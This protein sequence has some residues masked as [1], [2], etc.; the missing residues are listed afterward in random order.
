MSNNSRIFNVTRGFSLSFKQAVRAIEKECSADW[1]V[2]GMSIRDRSLAESLMAR[3]E[4]VR[5]REPLPYAEI[6]GLSY[7]PAASGVTMKRLEQGLIREACLFAMSAAK[8][9]AVP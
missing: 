1:E 4:Q 2:Y 6:P 5:L 9:A 3:A 7:E 8:F